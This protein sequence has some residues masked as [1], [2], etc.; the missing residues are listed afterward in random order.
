MDS[1]RIV[2]F[3]YTVPILSCSNSIETPGSQNKLSH[4]AVS[5]KVSGVKSHAVTVYVYIC[6]VLS[7]FNCSEVD[8]GRLKVF[9]VVNKHSPLFQYGAKDDIARVN[10]GTKGFVVSVL[11]VSYLHMCMSLCL[12]A[13]ST[14][15]VN[16]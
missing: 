3:L 14:S 11:T 15:S 6:S 12:L 9:R 1:R 5:C 16:F 10:L 7:R 13:Y 8:N 2:H 4:T